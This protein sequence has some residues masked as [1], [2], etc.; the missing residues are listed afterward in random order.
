MNH[1][2]HSLCYGENWVV[3]QLN[4]LMQGPDWDSTVVFI[5]WD[6]F[7]GVYD[8][9]PPP[10]PVDIYGFGPRSGGS[11]ISPYAKSGLHFARGL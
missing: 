10:A 5:V 8:H 7:G 11:V 9:V 6:D 2:P 3:E 1:P 4:A